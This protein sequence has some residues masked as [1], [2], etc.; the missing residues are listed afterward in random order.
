[1][2][3]TSDSLARPRLDAQIQAPVATAVMNAP[4]N[5]DFPPLV[6]RAA[7]P[8]ISA[9]GIC[10]A[11]SSDSYFLPPPGWR[12]W[13]RPPCFEL[14][15]LLSPRRLRPRSWVDGDLA[16]SLLDGTFDLVSSTYNSVFIHAISPI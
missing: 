1:M 14:S 15:L 9:D 12:P 2:R 3:L 11:G 13:R 7:R 10:A 16:D 8:I 6:W 4:V 5:I